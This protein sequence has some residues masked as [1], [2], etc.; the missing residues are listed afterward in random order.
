MIPEGSS[1]LCFCKTNS[2][3][4]MVLTHFT[5]LPSY[6]SFSLF[7]HILEAGGI[8]SKEND[9]HETR[10]AYHFTACVG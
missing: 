10:F 8:F 1:A 5:L 2:I 4:S 7:A 9:N 6:R 3:Y